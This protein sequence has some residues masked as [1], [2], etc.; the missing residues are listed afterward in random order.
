MDLKALPLSYRIAVSVNTVVWR[1]KKDNA[2]NK[3]FR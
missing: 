3:H 2:Q 1:L